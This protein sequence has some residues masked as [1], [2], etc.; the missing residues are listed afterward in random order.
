[1]QK[2]DG[3]LCNQCQYRTATARPN[4]EQ[5]VTSECFQGTRCFSN[6]IALNPAN[7]LQGRPSS[8]PSLYRQAGC[9]SET[10]IWEEPTWLHTAHARETA[11]G[12]VSSPRGGCG[13]GRAGWDPLKR[14][15]KNIPRGEQPEPSLTRQDRRPW[16]KHRI[17]D[18]AG[19]GRG[20]S[21]TVKSA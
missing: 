8:A 5:T 20:G 21:V 17:C 6:N 12:F 4:A 19:W 11:D 3:A 14:R 16:P 9:V 2:S 7:S 10:A 13:T 1:M 18:G 15:G